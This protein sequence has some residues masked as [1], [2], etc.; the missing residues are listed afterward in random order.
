MKKVILPTELNEEFPHIRFTPYGDM[1][2]RIVWLGE[3]KYG[4]PIDDLHKAAARLMKYNFPN[5]ILVSFYWVPLAQTVQGTLVFN[6]PELF[7]TQPQPNV[8]RVLS[9]GPMG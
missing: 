7:K 1:M 8:D 4:S 9:H 5:L 3:Q 2:V 6:D